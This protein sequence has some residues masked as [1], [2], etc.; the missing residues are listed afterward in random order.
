MSRRELLATFLGASWAAAG[1]RDEEVPDLPP[2]RLVEPSRTV[3]HRIRDGVGDLVSRAGDMPDEDWQ[4]CDVVVVGGGVA[5]LSA[6]RRMVMSGCTDFV[7]LE[8]EEVAGGTARG[9]MLAQQACPWGA[10]YLPVPQKENRALVS[11]L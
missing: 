1:C 9:G 10:H 3:G 5:G 4:T 7:L 6:V 8:L 2:G 11:L